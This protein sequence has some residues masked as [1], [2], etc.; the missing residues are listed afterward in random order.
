VDPDAIGEAAG[1]ATMDS[2][3]TWEDA[4]MALG[5]TGE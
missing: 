5:A 2:L 4:S 1:D 3:S